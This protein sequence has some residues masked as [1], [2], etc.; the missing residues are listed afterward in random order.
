MNKEKTMPKVLEVTCQMKIAIYQAERGDALEVME[1]R[2]SSLIDNSKSENC[3]ILSI[4]VNA[5][6]SNDNEKEDLKSNDTKDQLYSELNET[7]SKAS[8]IKYS[9][10]KL[11]RGKFGKIMYGKENMVEY[12]LLS[13]RFLN[14]SNSFDAYFYHLSIQSISSGAFERKTGERSESCKVIEIEDIDEA[15]AVE[16]YNQFLSVWEE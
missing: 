15:K 16:R 11:V 12:V 10:D 14:R 7:A 9:P 4:Q 5:I 1:K 8:Y 2:I 3:E 13:D 6:T